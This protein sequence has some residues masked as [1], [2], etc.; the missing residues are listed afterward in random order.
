[1]KP[2]NFDVEP[3]CERSKLAV[4]TTLII[5]GIA[6]SISVTGCQTSG[7]T[8]LS[9]TGGDGPS[10]LVSKPVA[11][12][13][14][15]AKGT[16]TDGTRTAVEV[17]TV[18]FNQVQ[19]EDSEQPAPLEPPSPV[20]SAPEVIL[21]ESELSEPAEII[22]GGL[23]PA[24]T[25]YPI[26]LMTAMR[27]A[28]ANHLQ[29]ALA[30][31]RIREACAQLQQAE[32]MWVPNLNL[33][34]GYNRHDGPIQDTSGNVIDVSRQSLYF[35]GGA[36]ISGAP[37][38]G[39]SGGPA[40][41]FVDLSTADVYFEPLAAR[42]N[43]AG[44]QHARHVAQNDNVLQVGL[45]YQEL[46]RAQ[47][48]VD[49]AQEAIGNA[50]ELV[51][52]TKNFEDAGKGLAADTQ[53]AR[54]ELEQRRHQLAGAR[55]RVA[56]SSAELV[57][58][59]RLDQATQLTAV[60]PQPLPVELIATDTPIE[61]L[62]TQGLSRRPELA[63]HQARVAETMTRIKQ[64]QWRPW[65]PHL[66]LG[67]AGGGFGGGR[68][69]DLQNFGVRGDFDALAIWQV[70]NFGL[71][72][73]ARQNER[74]SQH[75]QAHLQ[76]EWI[77]DQVIAEVTQ[78]WSRARYRK[79]QIEFAEQQVAAATDALPL[80]LKGIRDGVIRPIE[81]QQAI[82]GLAAA[83]SLYLASVVDFNRAQLELIRALGEPP[84]DAM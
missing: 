9:Q 58:L 37:L 20:V 71:G 28:G 14:P 59:L 45:A 80:N 66:H 52:L 53:R 57:R 70:Q 6:A 7:A 61:S 27:L 76:Y 62:V 5:V 29:I 50:E 83:R 73:R 23:S 49:V 51:D 72:N 77:R 42:Q 75:R 33:G 38:T 4:A 3:Q 15:S 2:V 40:R 65:L 56:V 64:E 36:G 47:L 34:I 48:Q 30:T 1:M 11:E 43:V 8:R 25:E 18:A 63:V 13:I 69:S 54:A 79:E 31:E 21:S 74:S 68:N 26:D 60:D 35:G 19:P 22:D 17:R 16:A 44:A 41:L 32:V 82:A 10:A 24:S 84:Q 12:G 55:E 81:A 46:V 67:Y 78:A 39:A